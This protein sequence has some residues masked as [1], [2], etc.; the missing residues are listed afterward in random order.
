[1][2]SRNHVRC[3]SCQGEFAIRISVGGGLQRFV[4]PCPLCSAQ[5][6]GEFFAEQ[7]TGPPL[8][9]SSGIPFAL[10]SDDF[11][12]LPYDATRDDSDMLAVAVDTEIPVHVSMF[13]T[14]IREVRGTPFIRFVDEAQH[15][16]AFL[17]AMQ[18]VSELRAIRF[19]LLPPM[20]RAA[21]FYG[22]GD[23]LRLASELPNIP[24]YSG[25]DFAQ[26]PPWEAISFL[27]RMCV[28]VIGA[29]PV[30]EPANQE[31]AS[32]LQ[33]AQARDLD[34]V[35]LTLNAYTAS[36]LSTARRSMVDTFLAVFNDGDALVPGL[37][38]EAAPD[39][40][41]D[42]FRI[43][44][45]DF[46]AVK[47]R[48]QDIFELASRVLVLPAALANIAHRGD[49]RAYADGRRRSLRESLRAKAS[50]RQAWLGELPDTQQLYSD[51]S[52]RTRNLIGHRLVNY[53][54]ER[55]ALIDDSGEPHNYLLFL[56]DYLKLVR[57]LGYVVDLVEMST[58]F[59]EQQP[60]T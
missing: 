53:D 38:V 35:G 51:A 47:S 26:A 29:E 42:A 56:V 7:P 33:Q 11:E 52:R 30:C 20:R 27:F 12:P 13:A 6:K 60:T 21:V 2:V 44:R 39:L 10:R 9:E 19:V 4:F 5:L 57:T 23:M 18:A 43:Q 59:A 58:A 14:P 41:I 15:T 55:S 3:R 45:S 1:M 22:A 28:G 34:A 40:D 17:R 16:D 46:D 8:P 49:P 25:S 32:I 24:G 36:A 31:L 50:T 48:Y 37:F 54:Y